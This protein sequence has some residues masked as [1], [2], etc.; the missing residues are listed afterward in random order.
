[1]TWSRGGNAILSKRRCVME[2]LIFQ[3][4]TRDDFEAALTKLEKVDVSKLLS[5]AESVVEAYDAMKPRLNQSERA[6]GHKQ[7][8]TYRLFFKIRAEEA[9]LL[10]KAIKSYKEIRK[11][12]AER[13]WRVEL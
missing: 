12:L 5:L 11:D 7:F 3:D 10:V 4:K 6:L 9:Y 1:M 13:K 8:A 2:S